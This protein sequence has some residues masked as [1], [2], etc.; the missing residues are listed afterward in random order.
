[1]S[2]YIDYVCLEAV[3]L[4]AIRLELLSTEDV[5]KTHKTNSKWLLA[6]WKPGGKENR[7]DWWLNKKLEKRTH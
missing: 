3:R 7:N 6:N 4:Y 2:V 5:T 1:M